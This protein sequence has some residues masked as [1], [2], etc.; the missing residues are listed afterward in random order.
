MHMARLLDSAKMPGSYSLSS[1]TREYNKYIDP[2][3]KKYALDIKNDDLTKLN[4]IDKT[5]T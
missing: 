5:K 3:T 1:L 2:L 4:T